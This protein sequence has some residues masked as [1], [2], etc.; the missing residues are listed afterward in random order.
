MSTNRYIEIV[1]TNVPSTGRISFRGGNPVIQFIIG[2]SDHYLL[3]SSIRIAGDFQCWENS[4]TLLSNT[5]L[6]QMD[7]KTGLY[8]CFNQLVLKNHGQFSTIE[9]IKSYN[10]F[11]ASYL[12]VTSALSDT[13]GH[14]SNTALTT[15]NYN[16]TKGQNEHNGQADGTR[17]QNSFS[18]HLP[19]GFLLGQQPIWLSEQGG[20]NGLVLELHLESD[21]NVFHANAETPDA[22]DGTGISDTFYE[23]SNLKLTAELVEPDS[24][25]IASLKA[26][27]GSTYAYNS[28]SSYYT[29]VNSTQAIV[30]FNLG[31]RNVLGAFA[32]F[33]PSQRINNYRF[34]GMETRWLYNGTAGVNGAAVIT[35]LIWT[36]GGTKFPLNYDVETIQKDK[37]LNLTSDPTV[38]RSFIDSVVQ[39]SKPSRCSV[40]PNNTFYQVGATTAPNTTASPISTDNQWIN[41]GVIAGIGQSY[42]QVSNQGVDFSRQNFGIQMTCDLTTDNP[43]GL[44]LFIHS[45]QTLVFNNDGLQI[46]K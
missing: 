2:A 32:N 4:T 39:F 41:N 15:S 44:Y 37:P 20:I 12:P 21:N 46:I 5:S 26:S 29:S 3:G 35:N 38:I 10:R 13:I 7:P 25:T 18:L 16:L 33:I 8:S 1:P 42:D 45:R 14:F 22:A 17:P 28:I 40:S 36:K 24:A 43:T 6:A 19:S 31:L 9:Q 11:M 34:N 23:F 27:A 30:N